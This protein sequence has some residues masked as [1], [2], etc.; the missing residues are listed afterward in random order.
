MLSSLFL[1]FLV[2]S[3]KIP[4]IQDSRGGSDRKKGRKKGEERSGGRHWGDTRDH[5]PRELNSGYPHDDE[6]KVSPSQPLLCPNITVFISSRLTESSENER[7]R[8]PLPSIER[9]LKHFELPSKSL[10]NFPAIPSLSSSSRE[11]E[12]QH[13]IFVLFRL[14]FLLPRNR[15][16]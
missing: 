10:S 3:L 15:S 1:H 11:R 9:E 5:R 16:L 7:V 8:Y 6:A 13:H 14:S 12:T 4:Q 2:T